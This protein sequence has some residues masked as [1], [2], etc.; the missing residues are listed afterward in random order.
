MQLAGAVTLDHATAIALAYI[1]AV[2]RGE[3]SIA[4][5]YLQSGL[6]NEPFA[7]MRATPSDVRAARDADGR[8]KI[9]AEIA[10]SSGRYYE[11]F[12]IVAGP[13]GLQIADHYTI[14]VQ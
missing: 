10:T 5:S 11:T 8:F 4:T 13:S 1:G 9:A 2:A 3:Q 12:T 7:G 6:P 14:K